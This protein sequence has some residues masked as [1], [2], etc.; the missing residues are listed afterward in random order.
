M[1]KQHQKG[2]LDNV[3]AGNTTGTEVSEGCTKRRRPIRITQHPQRKKSLA[4]R[5]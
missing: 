4:A 1:K 2:I 5:T 3:T